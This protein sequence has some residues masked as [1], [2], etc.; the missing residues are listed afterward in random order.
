MNEENK[1]YMVDFLNSNRSRKIELL[2][3]ELTCVNGMSQ[4][5]LTKTVNNIT[6]HFQKSLARNFNLAKYQAN[7]VNRK[8]ENHNSQKINRG[9]L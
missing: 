9:E 4:S 1:L 2:K 6:D 3:S 5:Q 8:I 7:K